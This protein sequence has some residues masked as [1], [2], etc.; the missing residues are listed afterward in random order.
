VS[1]KAFPLTGGKAFF[2]VGKAGI[3]QLYFHLSGLYTSFVPLP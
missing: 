1:A 3:A 2:S